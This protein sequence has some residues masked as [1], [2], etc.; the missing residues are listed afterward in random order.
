MVD[1][2]F[3]LDRLDENFGLGGGAATISPWSGAVHG[4]RLGE[5]IFSNIARARVHAE[6]VIQRM[7][8]FQVLKEPVPWEMVL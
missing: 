3:N 1:A 7:K 4:R 6:R 8:V 5:Q 2:G